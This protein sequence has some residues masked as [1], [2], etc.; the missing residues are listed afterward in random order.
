M[1]CDACW[2]LGFQPDPGLRIAS[3]GKPV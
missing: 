2:E 3:V 1:L